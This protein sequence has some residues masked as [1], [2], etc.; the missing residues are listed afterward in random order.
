M[1]PLRAALD[2]MA[3]DVPVYGD[4]DRAIEQAEQERRRLR[5]VLGSLSVA[6][7]VLVVIAGTLMVTRAYDGTPQP[8]EPL[9][10]PTEPP[11]APVHVKEAVRYRYVLTN[12]CEDPPVDCPRDT[13]PPPPL[14]I[15]VT[16]PAGWQQLPGYPNV[17]SPEALT[18]TQ[19]PGRG[20]ARAGL[21]QLLGEALLRPL[22]VGG[23]RGP[24][25]RG[26]AECRRLRRRGPGTRRTR[27]HQAVG[28]ADRRPPRT[29]LHAEDTGGHQ[30]L[31]NS[32][33]H[34]NRGSTRKGRA[35]SGTS[36]SSTSTASG[37]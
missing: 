9:L 14:D 7:A 25:H 23:R 1:N 29:L 37:C 31:R 34:G 5:A 33:D 22:L 13:A 21:D 8:M 28:R 6:A 3:A 32:G 30:R 10:G 20:R 27:G 4:L 26:R 36:G 19:D 11:S 35:T 18:P 17:I 24:R 16:V 2:E 15:E 12:S